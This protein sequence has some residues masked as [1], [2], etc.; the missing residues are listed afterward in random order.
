MFHL[1]QIP[2]IA[3]VASIATNTALEFSVAELDI[4][5][6]YLPLYTDA[7][8]EGRYTTLKSKILPRL[9]SLNQE[10]TSN[11]WKDRKNV[12]NCVYFYFG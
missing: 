11:D 5:K 8:K 3:A 10:L 6:K 7:D 12:R 1:P 4:V 9:F 2:T